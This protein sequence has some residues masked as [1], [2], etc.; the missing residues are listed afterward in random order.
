MDQESIEKRKGCGIE[1][2]RLCNG[3]TQSSRPQ[4]LKAG[5]GVPYVLL[6]LMVSL[7]SGSAV[8]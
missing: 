6:M 8:D 5:F 1:W 7:L 4:V 2:K 3:V